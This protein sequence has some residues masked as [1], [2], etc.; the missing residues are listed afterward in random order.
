MLSAYTPRNARPAYARG[1]TLIEIM[2]VVAIVGIIAAVAW[3]VYDSQLMAMQRK[4]G[5]NVL[6]TAAHEMELCK[7]DNGSYIKTDGT[8][9]A[10]TTVVSPKLHYTVTSA[11]TNGGEGYT[12]TATK[13]N[14]AN[15]VECA[16]LTIDNLNQ[17]S[18]GGTAPNYH[19]CWGD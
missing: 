3:Q 17:K 15:D 18:F 10:P 14:P 1:F 2:T 6:V 19:R 16:T 11:I 13:T 7:T 9:C 12:L 8:D 5:I 4:D